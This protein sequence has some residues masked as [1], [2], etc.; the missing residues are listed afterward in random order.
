MSENERSMLERY[1][2]GVG[3]TL[4][5]EF[6]LVRKSA[7]SS[8]RYLDGLI[9]LEIN[10]RAGVALSEA[11]EPGPV[12]NDGALHDLQ[13]QPDHNDYHHHGYDQT[14]DVPRHSHLPSPHPRTV[15]A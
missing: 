14:H 8:P 10:V 1:W 11:G 4:F 9:V 15:L 5:L 2:A 6:P 3:G 12:L 7:D 13:Y